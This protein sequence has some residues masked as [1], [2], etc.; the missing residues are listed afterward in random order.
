MLQ[1]INVQGQRQMPEIKIISNAKARLN[2]EK[3]ERLPIRPPT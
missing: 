1:S 2:E 3:Q